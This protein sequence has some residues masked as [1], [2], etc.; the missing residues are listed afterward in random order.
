MKIIGVIPS[1]YGNSR[2]L[3]VQLTPLEFSSIVGPHCA[4][5]FEMVPGLNVDV[6]YIRTCNN[7]TSDA[8]SKLKALPQTL[9]ALA[10][11]LTREVMVLDAEEKKS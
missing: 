9:R 5:E 1:R 4:P 6:N 8:T 7:A 3:I 11:I 2:E 10:E